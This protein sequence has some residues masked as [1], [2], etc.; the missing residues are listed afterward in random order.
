MQRSFFIGNFRGEKLGR[1]RTISIFFLVLFVALAL[2]L[3]YIQIVGHEDLAAATRA[4]SLISLEGSNTRGI[5]YDRN[6]AALVADKKSYVY[7]IKEENYT[8]R[9]EELL[10]ELG[11]DKISS[12]NEGYYVYS[13]QHYDKDAGGELIDKCSAYV[14]QAAARYSD[15]QTAVHLIGYVNKMDSSGAAGLE[16]MY[17]DQLSGLNRR[18][19]AVADVNGN[20]LPGRG[21]M[22]ASNAPNDTYVSEGIRTTLDKDL[23]T[24]IEK[25]IGEYERECAVVVLDSKT[26]GVAAMACTPKFDPDDVTRYTAGTGDELVNKVTQGEYPPGSVFKI[27]VAAAALEKGIDVDATYHCSG[28]ISMESVTIG[29]ET[30]GDEGHGTIGFEEAF[31]QSCNSFFVQ[32]GMEVGA[33]EII[34]MAEKM[35]FGEK[36]LEGFPQESAGHMMSETER[37]G[38]AIGNLSIGQGETLVTPLQVAVMTSIIAGDGIYKGAHL[39]MNDDAD[40]GQVISQDTARKIA[41]MMEAVTEK[42][43]ASG[44][45][46]TASDG[47]PKAAVKTGTAEYTTEE[48]IMT[49]SWMTGFS[50]CEDSEY[51]ITVMVEGGA[52]KTETAGPVFRR[53]IEYLEESGSYSKPTLT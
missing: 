40:T 3:A 18:V 24:E 44:A 21:L 19:Y 49:H 37:A 1:I 22:I 15:D 27:V 12:D 9:A 11:A 10:S 52:D 35:G 5:I 20:I 29:C 23:Q 6:G 50:P 30:G 17:D 31:A 14:L 4:Q 32:L 25:I 39:L 41:D 48:G 43:T 2:R 47:S 33:D 51:V 28:S 26:G 34:S 46:L 38:D 8:K 45:G 42:G 53:I 36:V 16:L 7:I 13:S